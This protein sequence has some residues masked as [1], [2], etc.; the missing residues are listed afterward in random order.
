MFRKKR[1]LT[2]DS[3]VKFVSEKFKSDDEHPFLWNHY[4]V[5]DIPNHHETRGYQTVSNRL[6]YC[7]SFLM[8]FLDRSAVVFSRVS[9]FWK[10]YLSITPRMEL[11]RSH[12]LR[13][14]EKEVDPLV[15]LQ[16][17]LLLCVSLVPTVHFFAHLTIRLNVL[18]ECIY[19]VTML[20]LPKASTLNSGVHAPNCFWTI[21]R[22]ISL[23]GTG[24][25]SLGDLPPFQP[26]QLWRLRLKMECLRPQR[27]VFPCLRLTL[28]RHLPRISNNTAAP[29]LVTAFNDIVTS[30]QNLVITSLNL[31]HIHSS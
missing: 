27:N 31:I 23:K 25:E 13:I 14:Q 21:S 2:L 19:P 1:L 4:V 9:Q 16:L 24:M 30:S 28:R 29:S 17:L 12:Q 22:L 18:T 15:P 8:H 20:K 26:R 5:G 10:H 7:C 6:L 3:R 11:W